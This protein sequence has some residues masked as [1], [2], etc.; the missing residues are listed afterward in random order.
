MFELLTVNNA[1]SSN[2]ITSSCINS[3]HDKFDTN[4]LILLHKFVSRNSKISAF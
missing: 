4:G 3:V 2:I 1:A